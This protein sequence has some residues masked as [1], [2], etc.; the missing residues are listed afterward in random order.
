MQIEVTRDIRPLTMEERGIPIRRKS[1]FGMFIFFLIYPFASLIYSLRYYRAD[2]SKNVLWL[3]VVFFGFTFVISNPDMDANRQREYLENF[4]RSGNNFSAI[5]SLLYAETNGYVDV[6]QPIVMFLVSRVTD[7]YRI[8]F[9]VYGIIF[10]FFYSRNIC[11]LIELSGPRIK[12]IGLLYIITF[13]LIIGFWQINGFRMWTAAHVFFYGTIR[14]IL[15]R[16]SKGV[17]IA[18]SSV[19][20]H[21]SYML[22]VAALLLFAIMKNRTNLYYVFFILTFFLAQIDLAIIRETLI[23]W[24]PPVFDEKI[25][26]YTH[27]ATV[28]RVVKS[29]SEMNWYA[30]YYE[31]G[32]RWVAFFLL[33]VFHFSGVRNYSQRKDLK[34]LLGFSLFFYGVIN[35]IGHVPSLGRFYS[36]ANLF[37]IAFIFL[38]IQQLPLKQITKIATYIVIPAVLLFAVVSI[39]TAFDMISLLTVLGNPFIALLVKPEIALIQIVKYFQ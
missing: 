27:V 31:M 15:E 32:L 34:E 20:I 17:L 1:S 25:T 21:F 24:L 22:P 8:L 13:A 9:A 11:Y 35:I 6:F 26:S 2:Y 28:E 19:F 29:Y 10:G 18:A 16:K 38:S 7:N 4:A 5:L 3:F 12:K 37:S 23:K 33:S 30:A 14:F 36:V 39:R